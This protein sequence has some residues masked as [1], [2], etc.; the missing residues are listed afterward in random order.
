[1][2]KLMIY[3]IGRSIE[4]HD[5]PTVRGIVRDSARDDYRFVSI[6]THIVK[7]DPFRMKQLPAEP[8]APAVVPKQAAVIR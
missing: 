1:V 3:G 6:I 2:Q 5:M 7:S 8:A 4:Y